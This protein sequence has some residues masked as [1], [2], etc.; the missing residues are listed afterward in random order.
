MLI[1]RFHG[2]VDKTISKIEKVEKV[3]LVRRVVV[4]T[5]ASTKCPPSFLQGSLI[6]PHARS[7]S[8]SDLN[9][10]PAARISHMDR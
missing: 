5:A 3:E 6:S 1:Q 10:A 4:A 7:S 2:V 9:F 8:F